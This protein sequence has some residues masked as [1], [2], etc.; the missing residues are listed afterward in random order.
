MWLHYFQYNENVCYEYC[1][2]FLIGLLR[3]IGVPYEATHVPLCILLLLEWLTYFMASPWEKH[4]FTEILL[5]SCWDIFLVM[6]TLYVVILFWSKYRSR[7]IHPYYNIFMLLCIC[8]VFETFMRT[9]NIKTRHLTTSWKYLYMHFLNQYSVYKFHVAWSD[10]ISTS[11]DSCG[12]KNASALWAF[13]YNTPHQLLLIWLSWIYRQGKINGMLLF[14][15]E[16]TGLL[17]QSQVTCKFC[18][19]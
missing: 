17:L 1:Q 8:N 18:P 4:L 14:L 12:F 10:L 7:H 16:T 6:V 19:Y 15:H 3:W 2:L 11:L 9:H 5:K 13:I